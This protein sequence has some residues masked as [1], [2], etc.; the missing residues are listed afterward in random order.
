MLFRSQ[1]IRNQLALVDRAFLEDE[2][3]AETFL[4]ILNQ[5]GNVAPVLRAMHEVDLLGKYIPEF[6]KLTCLVQH[7]FYHQYTADEH[8]LVCLE[9]LDQVWEAKAPPFQ[10]YAPIFQNLERP[11]LLYLALL[12]HDTGKSDPQ[13]SHATVGAKLAARVARR[14]RLDASATHILRSVIEHHLLMVNLSQRRDMDD[15]SVIRQFAR[16]MQQPEILNLLTLHT[17]ADS[18]GTSD[19]LWNG[20]KDSLLRELRSRTLPLLTGGTEFVRAEEKQRE[21]LMQEVHALLPGSVSDEELHAHFATL[22]PRYFQIHTAAEVL[23]DLQLAHE[24]IQVQVAGG[25]ERALAPAIQWRDRKSTRLNSS[26]PRLSRMPS[27][28]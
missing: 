12:L 11:F 6:G 21:E 24:F 19:K 8:T 27:S 18:L 28:D 4:T 26:H 25:D 22:P 10:S 14:L 20:F 5:R 17:F 23:A 2:H 15:I 3:V 1:L 9:K 16:Q 7:E 13:T